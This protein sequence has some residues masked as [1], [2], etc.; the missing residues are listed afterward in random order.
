MKYRD[1]SKELLQMIDSVAAKLAKTLE[2]NAKIKSKLKASELKA[3]KQE[4]DVLKAYPFPPKMFSFS[5]FCMFQGHAKWKEIGDF[6][7]QN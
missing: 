3:F 5:F 7:R 1:A 2:L 4:G 6:D